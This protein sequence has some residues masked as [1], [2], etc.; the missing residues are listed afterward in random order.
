MELEAGIR[1]RRLSGKVIGAIL[2]R[3]LFLPG[4]PEPEAVSLR[5]TSLPIDT[6][7]LHSAVS[8]RRPVVVL[9]DPSLSLKREVQ[10]PKAALSRADAAV[11]LQLRQT[12]PASGKGLIWR[13]EALALNGR[14]VDLAAYVVK[15][16]LI[17]GL[18]GDMKA[19][20]VD[21]SSI[22]IDGTRTEPFWE[23]RTGSREEAKKWAAASAMIVGLAALASVVSLELQ[24]SELSALVDARQARVTAL[25]DRIDAVSAEATESAAEASLVAADLERFAQQSRRL[26]LLVGLT[27]TLPDTV[28]IAELSL[29]GADMTL[30]GFTSGEVADLLNLLQG[31]E[32]AQEVQLNGAATFD[33]YS[34]QNRFD[35]SLR[36][37]SAGGQ[38]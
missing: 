19:A 37:V 28:W 18:V 15:E 26:G 22:Q 33:S 1:V 30:S 35:I 36:V 38:P 10:L 3:W 5:V 27:E 16:N 32:W 12:L 17:A 2:P 24:I 7:T 31:L 34:G 25:E 6:A 21:L 8:L 29:S 13:S 23:K 11:D 14:L 9:L 4:L 20:G